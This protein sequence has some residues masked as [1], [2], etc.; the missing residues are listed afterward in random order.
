VP[1]SGFYPPG[2]RR[3]PLVPWIGFVPFEFE[4]SLAG[5]YTRSQNKVSSVREVLLNAVF[6]FE[7]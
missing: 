3:Y 4:S 6:S 7:I 5:E 1:W 2:V